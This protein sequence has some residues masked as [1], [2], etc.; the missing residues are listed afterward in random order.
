M[1]NHLCE[2][3]AARYGTPLLVY[4]GARLAENA[5]ATVSAFGGSAEEPR[6]FFP[7]KACYLGAVLRLLAEIGLGAE[8][9]SELEF[10]LAVRAGFAPARIIFNGPGKTD[11]ELRLAV[12]EGVRAIH[13]ESAEELLALNEIARSHGRPVRIG[14]R[15]HVPMPD[16]SLPFAGAGWKFGADVA[17]GDALALIK[18]ALQQP[19]L[20]LAGLH[21]HNYA[22]QRSAH[23]HLAALRHLHGLVD[24]VPDWTPDYVDLGGGFAPRSALEGAGTGVQAIACALRRMASAIAPTLWVEP[25]RLIVSDAAVVLTRVI[26]Q[27]V[28]SGRRWLL[29]DAATNFLVPGPFSRYEVQPVGQI[30]GPLVD[31]AVGDGLCL[32]GGVLNR[33]AQLP[34]TVGTGDL[35]AVTGAGAYTLNFGSDFG[36]PA[37]AVLWLMGPESEPVLLRPRSTPAEISDT[38]H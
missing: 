7:V 4:G 19:H 20:R 23:L 30:D 31:T 35:L 3:L 17:S 33:A 32:P 2:E 21:V 9:Q 18:L 28:N 26:R 38:W 27:K 15:V 10:H 37:P 29:V 5:R 34:A 16:Q 25:G 6:V 13:V 8:V 36:Y 12:A 1:D 14:I 24:Q 22:Q 11:G